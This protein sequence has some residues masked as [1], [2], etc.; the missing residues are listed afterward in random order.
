[1]NPASGP[2]SEPGPALSR[3]LQLPVDPDAEALLR[4]A[5]DLFVQTKTDFPVE[6]A[7]G[8][9]VVEILQVLPID[10]SAL[11]AGLFLPLVE[12]GALSSSLLSERLDAE[13]AKLIERALRLG[14]LSE[15]R[16]SAA[17]ATQADKLRKM[18]LTMAQDPRV[19]VIGLS[20]QL[21]RLR[22][23]K[24]Q[25]GTVQREL[26][27][28]ALQLYA[29]LAGRLGIW[30]F[31][32]ELEDLAFRYLQPDVYKSLAHSLDQRRNE[33]ER[34]IRTTIAKLQEKL[35]AAGIEAEIAGRP[36]HI[37]SIWKKM[38]NK[39][40]GFEQLFD[41]LALRVL[42]P[43]VADCYATLSLVQSLWPPIA[44]EFD[45]YIAKP[46]ANRYQSLHTAVLGPEGRPMEVQ[47]R[48]RAMHQH[49]EL[50]VAAHWRYKERSADRG[51]HIAWLKG[52]LDQRELA[53]PK[54]DLIER[55]KV[56]AF[57]NRIYVLTPQGQV[58]DLPQGATAL[59]FA[60]ALHTELGHRCRGAKVDGSIVP[61][62]QALQSGQQVE[63]LTT[64]H[65]AP[66]RDWLSPSLGYLH[67]DSAR[68]KIKRWFKQQDHA[69]HVTQGRDL[70]ERESRRIGRVEIDLAQVARHF[71]VDG[72]EDLFAALGRGDISGGQLEHYLRE[73]LTPVADEDDPP[74]PKKPRSAGAGGVHVLGV[75]NLLTRFAGCCKPVPKD[76]IVGYITQGQGVS[77]HRAIC[78]NLSQLQRAQAQRFVEVAWGPTRG[79][80]YASEILVEIADRKGLLRDVS[81]VVNSEH[82]NITAINTTNDR[83]THVARLN[84]TVE[85]VDTAQ[86]ER[87][88]HKL[89]QLPE[90]R[91]ARRKLV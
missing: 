64:R 82:V 17:T 73:Q 72:Q 42:V 16:Q 80:V 85:I 23:A 32:W 66:S 88:L 52:F 75:S 10:N 57:Q 27:N 18:W 22:A 35:T 51:A 36:K 24:K 69:R 53:D 40:L 2:S 41:V 25:P 30:Q 86:L 55:F 60:Y 56:Q 43:E 44:G 83:S 20:D 45:D 4:K 9:A 74:L 11:V 37:Y 79:N 21:E 1:M 77:I 59:D 54:H 63:I 76:A 84:L 28:D 31:K 61:L 71:H 15:Y 89:Q 6:Y 50:G 78:R 62:V 46:K 48:T 70:L 39:Q 68:N 58:V 81:D 19:V 34:Y 3:L 26:A 87:V 14:N 12:A 29:P 47:I 90:A 33:R 7:R 13:I 67:T 91:F 5:S 8:I 38:Q 49:A 65:G